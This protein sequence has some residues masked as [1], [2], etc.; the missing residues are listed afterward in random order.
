[1]AKIMLSPLIVDIRNKQADTVFSKWRGINYIRSRVIP[2][3]PKSAAQQ[4]IRD[5]LSTMVS[6]WQQDIWGQQ[7]NWNEYASGKSFSGY[8]GLLGVNIV[9]MKDGNVLD[10]MRPGSYDPLT[11]FSAA[12]GAGAKEIDIT[13]A[14]TPVPAG[15][16]LVVVGYEAYG[17][18]AFSQKFA[19]ATAS[20]Q[21]LTMPKAGTTY[22]LN[23]WIVE[24]ATP[25]TLTS[26]DK[27]DSAA[28][29]A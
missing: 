19:A 22:F 20:P 24:A 28:S 25:I 1:M 17:G 5:A 12:T 10:L 26:D 7:L 15:K 23:A 14:A 2:S 18:Y 13:F 9:D 11:A 8:N 6:N 29:H 21:T 16:E 4:N 27:N 3:N